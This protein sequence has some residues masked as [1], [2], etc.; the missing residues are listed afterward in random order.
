MRTCH[1]FTLYLLCVSLYLK[2]NRD[3]YLHLLLFTKEAA[4]YSCCLFKGRL[5]TSV[6]IYLSR[7]PFQD[8]R[9]CVM[10]GYRYLILANYCHTALWTVKL[11]VAQL[12]SCF[13]V[14]N[15]V[16]IN[17][18]PISI[19]LLHSLIS[20]GSIIIYWLW[21]R[22]SCLHRSSLGEQGWDA[23]FLGLGDKDEI[24]FH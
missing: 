11:T 19:S 12:V 16:S 21:K 4:I 20:P 9:H 18:C 3:L 5:L 7:W 6:I 2:E 1:I 17:S 22:S 13:T 24:L 14:T 15:A 10:F 8:I 23:P